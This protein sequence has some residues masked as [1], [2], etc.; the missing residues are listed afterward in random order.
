[1]LPRLREDWALGLQSARERSNFQLRA[2]S[3][4]DE[5]VFL[6][7]QSRHHRGE[8]ESEVHGAAWR[9][10]ECVEAAAIC[11]AQEGAARQAAR[12]YGIPKAYWTHE[13]MAA[14]PDLDIDVGARP[15]Y[16]C[17]MV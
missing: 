3:T 14:D 8:L 2:K 11:T 16:R 9:R 12:D 7:A 1:M 17:S 4:G 5:G 13:E 6:A 15:T 10:L